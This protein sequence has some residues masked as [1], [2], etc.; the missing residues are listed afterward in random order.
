[1]PFLPQVRDLY[2]AQGALRRRAG[3]R[4]A[5]RLRRRRACGLRP[6]EGGRYRGE[7]AVLLQRVRRLHRP[8][9][10]R[11]HARSD[12]RA[13][14]RA[15]RA[16]RRVQRSQAQRPQHGREEPA[17]KADRAG[18]SGRHRRRHLRR[19][20]AGCHRAAAKRSG[21]DRDR[22]GDRGASA[23]AVRGRNFR[24]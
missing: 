23:H 12:R 9:V 21:H 22:R 11:A 18:L 5:A 13:D 10:A 2:A 14:D 4:A 3:V 19:E 1:M 8:H 17:G 20:D 7:R 16:D 6:P 15:D 24:L